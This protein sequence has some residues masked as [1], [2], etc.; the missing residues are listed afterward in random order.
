[1]QIWNIIFVTINA[2]LCE[3]EKEGR[4]ME[5]E[6]TLIRIAVC[7]DN[8]RI[9]SD[10]EGWI[11]EY[12]KGSQANYVVEI[13]YNGERLCKDMDS[14]LMY[15]IIFLDIELESITGIEVGHYIR[16]KLHN[17]DSQIIYISSFTK[18]ALGLFQVRPMDFLIKP[19]QKD[20]IIKSIE[21]ATKLLKKG[22][23]SF[24]YK[25]GRDWNKI[26]IKDILY[27]KGKDREVEMVTKDSVIVFYSP[28]EKVFDQLK[29]YN[30]FYAHKSFLINYF[31]VTD[32]FYDKLIMSNQDIIKIA[33]TRRREVRQMQKEYLFKEKI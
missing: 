5:V 6:R 25:Q 19:V 28:L 14:G 22:E 8:L 7:D 27:F 11:M 16:G 13:Y 4:F 2:I 33:Q 21:T 17:D 9:S 23:V 3:Y 12:N 1:M 18:Y 20:R 24:Q 31:H 10:I 26:Y 29:D 32:F 15:D 30:F